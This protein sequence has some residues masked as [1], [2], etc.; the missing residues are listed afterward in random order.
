MSS[1]AVADTFEWTNAASGQYNIP[2]NWTRTAGTGAAPPGDGDLALFNEPGTYSVNYSGSAETDELQFT[3][4]D[5]TLRSIGATRS[6]KTTDGVLLQGGD[7]TLGITNA[8]LEL[9]IGNQLRVRGG[10]RMDILHGSQV[11]VT[12]QLRIGANASGDGE[13]VVAGPGGST[14]VGM[15]SS[16]TLVG[17]SGSTGTLRF[18][19]H[20]VGVLQN[21]L[22]LAASAV[23]GSSAV[24]DLATNSTLDIAGNLRMATGSGSNQS[25]TVDINTHADLTVGGDLLIGTGTGTNQSAVLNIN[26]AGSTF[27]QTGTGGITVGGALGLGNTARLQVFR[28]FTSGTGP[29]TIRPSGVLQAGF[30]TQNING[31]ISIEAGGRLEITDGIFSANAGIDNS[32]FGTLE[33]TDGILNLGGGTTQLTPFVDNTLDFTVSGS[34]PSERPKLIVRDG[35]LAA[36]ADNLNVGAG[37]F[38]GDLEV[39][40]G[41]EVRSLGGLLAEGAGSQ[42]TVL[43]TGA[44][45]LWDARVLTGSSG[46][47]LLAI[48]HGG[49]A[50]VEVAD[51][52]RLDAL[53][54]LGLVAGASGTLDVHGAG[55]HFDGATVTV[56]SLG[57]GHLMIRDEATASIAFLDVGTRSAATSDGLV[58][59]NSDAEVTVSGAMNVG[60]FSGTSGGGSGVVRVGAGF[61]N[62]GTLI[63]E[64][65][66]DI[67]AAGEVSVSGGNSLLSAERIDHTLGG[68]F[69]MFSGTTLEVEIF[70]GDLSLSSANLAPGS[71]DTPSEVGATLITGNYTQGGGAALQIH[72]GGTSPGGTYDVVT[73]AGTA[74]L[75]GDLELNLLGGFTPAPTDTFVLLEAASITGFFDNVFSNQRLDVEGGEGSFLV[76]Y[77][78]GSAFPSNRIVLSDFLPAGLA[79]DY[80]DDGIVD[81]ADYAVWRDHLGTSITLPGDTTPGTVSQ[82]D[83]NVW[84]ANFGAT[85]ASL[86]IGHSTGQAVPEPQSL[87]LILLCAV[88]IRWRSIRSR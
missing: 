52:G 73:V 64:G 78:T 33:F 62:S 18:H 36:A 4:G 2:G 45:S 88:A 69:N 82:A 27:T 14:L 60:G 22:N 58:E 43:I 49:T 38:A 7:V 25:A 54:R 37:G 67:Y 48:G 86:A 41:G 81:A 51:G 28:T 71:I 6:H 65:D 30:G 35:A 29:V 76:H 80:N 61:S 46:D 79:G 31:P 11:I 15:S 12:G 55:S 57:Q 42:A 77:G 50:A 53:V 75:D 23:T 21:D 10:S 44:G 19:Q 72:V 63:V 47:P 70:D 8:P 39:R 3:A 24:L 20:A 5:V 17:S 74:D 32:M 84:R 40:A 87:A 26:G 56:G 59:I 34:L 13:V 85:A 16:A 9:L 68:T 1:L 66:L 83:Y